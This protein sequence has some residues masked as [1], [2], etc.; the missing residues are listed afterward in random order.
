MANIKNFGLVGVGSQVQFGKSGPQLINNSG[1]F[2]F[3]DAANA[4]DANVTAGNLT[5]SGNLEVNGTTTTVNTTSITTADKTFI[6]SNGA[7]TDT[8]ADGSGF[9]VQGATL[10]TFLYDYS[11]A[12]FTGSENMNIVTGKQYEIGGVPVLSATTLGSGIV[13]SGLT[14]VGTLT[15]LTVSGTSALN[16]AVTAG[17]TLA[18][19]GNTTVGGTLG[20]T[21]LT[22][23]AGGAAV[24]GG[25]TTDTLTSTGAA[26]LA[27]LAVTGNETVGGTLGV[28]GAT[29]LAATTIVGGLTVD[30]I[31]ASGA[32]ST[33][34]LTAASAQVTNLAGS[35]IRSVTVDANGNLMAGGASS[36]ISATTATIGDITITGDTISTDTTNANLVLA[37]NGTGIVTAPALTATGAVIAGS[38]STTGTLAAG[39]STLG[40]TTVT[41]GLTTDT[42]TTTGNAAVGGTLTVTGATTMAGVTAG[43]IGAASITTTGNGAIG[44]TFTV[45]GATT[46][47]GLTA[48][49][50]TLGATGITGGLT[51]DTITA[52]GAVSTGALTAASVTASNLTAGQVVFAGTAG[53]L[54]DS[55][56]L[57]FNSGTGVL[58]ATGFAT[59]GLTISAN[60]I[61]G[62][63]TPVNPSDAVNKSYVDAQVSSGVTNAGRAAYAA[64]AYTQTAVTVAS[65]ITGF[66]HRVK[67]YVNTAFDDTVDAAVQVG[68]VIGGTAV[69]NA[70]VATSDTDPTIAACYVVE[71]AVPVAAADLVINVT[72]GTSTQGAGYVV[73]EWI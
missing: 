57:T 4:N 53:A 1:V 8:A 17:S 61:T 30:T 27:S 51:V 13:N 39:A 9:E 29:T 68:T 21:G 64:F 6:L 50:T 20:V 66:V 22:T 34:A 72:G 71:L 73:I 10:H 14:S 37:P 47:A 65:A 69:A 18:V 62:L 24:T 42:L 7:A 11:N 70:L 49:A 59:A 32:V 56:A 44:G 54:T 12:A 48:G 45:T 25:L 58:T 28:T 35:G 2:A 33:G 52:S 55:S 31:A 40:A 23:L 60:M 19:T 46:L 36:S 5:L 41:G 67:V 15:S 63:A 43:A 38:F 3:R 16:G 26:T